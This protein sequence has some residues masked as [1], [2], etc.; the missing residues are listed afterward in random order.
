MDCSLSLLPTEWLNTIIISHDSVG[1]D[2]YQG[3]IGALALPHRA[4]ATVSE[5]LG[6][7]HLMEELVEESKMASLTSVTSV[8]MAKRLG[9]AKTVPS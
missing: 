2:F 6:G 1:Q 5:S 4:S 3:P 7:V 9:S 8:G